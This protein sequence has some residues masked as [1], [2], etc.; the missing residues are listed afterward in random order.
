MLVDLG[1]LLFLATLLREGAAR[2]QSREHDDDDDEQN[3]AA[4]ETS[5]QDTLVPARTPLALFRRRSWRN[6][7]A[8]KLPP[9]LLDQW[10]AAHEFAEP[11]IRFNL[12]SST[13]P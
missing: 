5:C 12:A 1:R 10:L 2:P 7:S 13:G 3:D 11:P 9:F 8:M 4:H 6:H